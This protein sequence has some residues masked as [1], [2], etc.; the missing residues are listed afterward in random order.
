MESSSAA[1]SLRIL[2]LKPS[3]YDEEGYVVQWWR[4]LV[5]TQ[6]LAVILGVLE[7]A[8]ERAVL[9][10]G[11]S[12]E[13][14]VVDEHATVVHPDRLL[15]WLRS[16]Q[17]G[18]VMLAGV[19]TN[20]YPRAVDLGRAFL[21]GGV[22]VI[23][24]GVHV[25]GIQALTPGWQPGLAAAKEAGISLFAG[26]LEESID[27]LLLDIWHDRLHP[28]YNRIQPFVDLSQAPP[29]RIDLQTMAKVFHGLAGM[30]LGRGCPYLC[31]FCT[32]INV[33]GRQLRCRTT[34]AMRNY[35]R[36]AAEM[37]IHRFLVVDDNFARNPD[38]EPFCDS[39]IEMRRK[40]NL[41]V[42]LF[43]QVD[44]R[45]TLIPGF[46]DKV[47]EAG[48]R[49]VFIGIESVRSDNLQD[50]AKK[51]NL[52]ADLAEMAMTWRRAGVIIY[53]AYII[54]FPHDTPERIAEDVRYLQREVRFDILE[55]FSLTPL[56][57]SVDHQQLVAAGSEL[58]LDFNRYTDEQPVC[59]HPQMDRTTWQKLYRDAWDWYYSDEH[60]ERTLRRALEDKL[61]V[62]EVLASLVLYYGLVRY[63][64]VHPLVGGLVRRRVRRQRRPG[65][66]IEPVWRFFPHRLW[67][68][69]R[70]QIGL[71]ALSWK[72]HRILRRIRSK[73]HM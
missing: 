73:T 11:T 61:P 62:K 47:V 44:A 27:T 5:P 68:T 54:G 34:D 60:L 49:R 52:R 12:L 17:R 59:D 24:G 42:E 15:S 31:S 43:L 20:Q 72:A 28:F 23:M 51:Q 32:V 55:F 26:E 45:A 57:G 41:P 37:G 6:A 25:S 38:W 35:V 10:P 33:H 8:R 13:V 69:L 70:A 65:L 19:Q 39:L 46:V 22:P 9:G 53:A 58:D 50:A 29:S 66:P 67:Q 2:L 3:H 21:A 48:C 1:P 71:M 16:A 18:V 56:P 7:D 64:D 30:D 63:E 36:Q 4:S 40:E 14:K